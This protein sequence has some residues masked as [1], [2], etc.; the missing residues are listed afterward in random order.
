MVKKHDYSDIWYNS[1]KGSEYRFASFK[2]E[3]Y[4]DEK[5]KSKLI[6][7]FRAKKINYVLYEV[8]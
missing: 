1:L 5:F 4:T 3:L 2:Y 7:D 8:D 6:K